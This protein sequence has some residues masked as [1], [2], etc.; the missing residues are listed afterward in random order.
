[1]IY[2]LVSHCYIL[3]VCPYLLPQVLQI[4]KENAFLG[5]ALILTFSDLGNITRLKEVNAD[6]R[7]HRRNNI[8]NV[9]LKQKQRRAQQAK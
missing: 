9:L 3:S 5:M 4:K 7:L 8:G 1:M 6:G 2:E